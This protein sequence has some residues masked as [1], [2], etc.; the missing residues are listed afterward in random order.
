MLACVAWFIHTR[1]G[2]KDRIHEL[3]AQVTALKQQGLSS[4]LDRS[5]SEQMEI[6]AHGQQALSEERSQEA[7]RQSAIAQAATIR[8]E[9]ERQNAMK[10]Q[11][12]AETSAAEALASYQMAERQRRDAE[13]ARMVTDT[14]N[15]ISLG[16]TLGSQ[17]YSI[18]QT[19]NTELGNMLAYASYLYTHDYG[20]DL[21]TPTVFQ[22]LMQSAGGRLSWNR[23][24]GNITRLTLSPYDGRL[25]T[26]STFGELFSHQMKGE[27]IQTT[28]LMNDKQYWFCDVYATPKGKVYAVS[29][30]GHL[31]IAD[32]RQTRVVHLETVSKPF[33]LQS[34]NDGRSLLV[35]GENSVA[36]IDIATDRLLA[37]RRL[38][39]QVISTGRRDN[40]PLLFDNRGHMHLVNSL[41]NMTNEKVPVAGKVTAYASSP[42]ERLAAYG[43]AD[44]TIWLVDGKGKAYKLVEHLSRVTRL[45]FNGQRLYSSSYDGKLL[46]WP[47]EGNSYFKAVTLYQSDNWL[48]DFTFSSDKDYILA[49]EYHGVITQCLISLPMIVQRLR[50][51][52]K[53]NFTHEEWNY[54]VGKGISYRKLKIED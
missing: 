28:S 8:S 46:F 6:I 15:Y 18:Y 3:E 44:G 40:K 23:H 25:L 19:G 47:I 30:T 27:Q 20:G 11:A 36:L 34:L 39:F 50:Q 13:H 9:A 48:S 31:V 26:V 29:Y 1:D 41:E 37:S 12:A 42:K 32:G 52:V 5:V 43:M 7:I 24:N 33:S 4:E 35:T 10:A 38:D 21:Y 2:D 22:A 53:R 17:S 49:G 14:L 54:Y 16:R 51:N 45:A